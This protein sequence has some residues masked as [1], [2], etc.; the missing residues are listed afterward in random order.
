MF[1]KLLR[2]IQLRMLRYA[3]RE[4]SITAI[5]DDAGLVRLNIG[6]G[7]TSI[8]GYINIDARNLPNVHIVSDKLT[9]DDFKNG[10]VSEIYLCHVLEHISH[11]NI[12]SI[13]SHYYE[14]LCPGGVLRLSVPDFR[15]IVHIY[16]DCGED[17]CAVELP[18]MGGQ[19]YEYNFHKAI[20]DKP[21]LSGKLQLAGFRDVKNW[22]TE[23]D[24]GGSVGD[25][26]D[27]KIEHAGKKYRISL[28]LKALK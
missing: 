17:I 14:K 19:D 27:L 20:Y 15:S 28:N 24:F 13:L 4:L 26:S 2:K 25:W 3:N 8:P 12:D 21:Y 23:E 11:L 18:L 5:R 6:S 9:L 1:E 10:T 7:N 16:Q 22:V